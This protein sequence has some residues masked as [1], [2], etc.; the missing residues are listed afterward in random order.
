MISSSDERVIAVQLDDG[1][2]KII[3]GSFGLTDLEDDLTVPEERRLVAEWTEPS[4]AMVTCKFHRIIA[5]RR[6]P[7]N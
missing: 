2:H 4:G 7:P 3:P 6:D 5:I 1:W